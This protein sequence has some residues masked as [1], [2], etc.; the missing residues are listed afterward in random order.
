M[1]AGPDMRRVLVTRPEP[2]NGRTSEKL[3]AFGLEA[4]QLPLTGI[5]PIHA[6]Q[7]PDPES[8]HAVAV[9][10]VNAARHAPE[11][12]L[13]RLA[14]T[15]CYAVGERTGEVASVAG[16][17]VVDSAGMD[18]E[19]LVRRITAGLAA[20]QK[21]LI[22]C[23]RVR[24]PILRDGLRAAG[25]EALIVETYN[26]VPYSFS[27]SEIVAKLGVEPV[28]AVLLYSGLA[29]EVFAGISGNRVFSQSSYFVISDRVGKMLA[30][31]ARNRIHV[32]REPTE[33]AILSLLP[34]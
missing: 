21:V 32:A 26:T 6:T 22:L 3:A 27:E 33:E 30:H 12:L 28:D 7:W 2:D 8:V 24:R 34:R 20:G 5:E 4:L 9:T 25:L 10:S 15:P 31:V 17:N 14:S 19:G 1:P 23:G 16:L 18:A 13:A 29:A 11:P